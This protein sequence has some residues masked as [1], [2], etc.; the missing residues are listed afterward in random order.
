MAWSIAR[1]IR[2][3]SRAQFPFCRQ[4]TVSNYCKH[5][6]TSA[7]VGYVVLLWGEHVLHSAM[8]N[9]SSLEPYLKWGNE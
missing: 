8:Q 6:A 2:R 7:A 5:D 1:G 4:Q 3:A 9:S